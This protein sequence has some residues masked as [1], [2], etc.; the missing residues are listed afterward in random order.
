VTGGVDLQ[1]YDGNDR[2]TV[3]GAATKTGPGVITLS[4]GAGNDFY[5]IL[6]SRATTLLRD[7]EGIDTLSFQGGARG[8]VIDLSLA[9]GQAQRWGNS[10]TLKLNGLIENAVGTSRA[11]TIKGN[12]AANRIHGGGGG[13]RLYGR[14]GD[15]SLL[16][17]SGNDILVG[18][19]GQD[20]LR[21]GTG[22]D[23]LYGGI[24]NDVL[25]GEAGTDRL[26]ASAGSDL[27]IGGLAA[28]QLFAGVGGNDLLLGGTTAFDSD[29]QALLAILA[30]WSSTR[31]LDARMSALKNGGGAND[32]TRLQ[33]GV[34]VFNDAAI[35]TLR[36][37]DGY[38]WLWRS[39]KDRLSRPA[40]TD[41]VTTY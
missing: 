29:N 26:Y 18:A 19:A 14:G 8:V 11:D 33:P 4:G 27:M 2:V 36:P 32:T 28:D 38:N 3:K 21:G 13:D 20:T 17:G 23:R 10:N 22:A 7:T 12:A 39:R 5:R 9:T 6:T 34:T 40:A 31:D 1:V 25:L 41:R 30:E 24:G 16:G 15:D 37:R 35:D